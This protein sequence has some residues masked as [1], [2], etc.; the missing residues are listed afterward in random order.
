MSSAIKTILGFSLLG[1]VALANPEF[2]HLFKLSPEE[3]MED[4]SDSYP[5]YEEYKAEIKE[6]P[7]LAV[8]RKPLDLAYYE[9]KQDR[10]IKP[11]PL[12]QK[13]LWNDGYSDLSENPMSEKTR[14]LV[15]EL[16]TKELQEKMLYWYIQYHT[17]LG[18]S[19]W[20]DETNYS[21]MQYK[22]HKEAY[23]I[24]NRF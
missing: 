17:A 13:V 15:E 14:R 9:V 22:E 1:M 21:Y 2:L 11:E 18:K 23:E 12:Q 7:K 20:T 4:K 8:H 3:E 10:D 16:S 24:K 5:D 19:G 6:Q